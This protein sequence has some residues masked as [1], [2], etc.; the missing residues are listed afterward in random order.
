M[1][2]YKAGEFHRTADQLL[3]HLLELQA[4]GV[5]LSKVDCWGWDDET[6]VFQDPEDLYPGLVND[7]EPKPRNYHDYD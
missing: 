6:I 5:D 3:A 7:F 4:K 1:T 2:A